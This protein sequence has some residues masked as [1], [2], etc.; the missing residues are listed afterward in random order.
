MA[1]LAM[2]TACGGT[3]D[4]E[5]MCGAH[6]DI[7]D[8]FN[9]Q[10]TG[11]DPIAQW[12]RAAGVSSSGVVAADFATLREQLAEIEGCDPAAT[13]TF[14]VSD[15]LLSTEP[16]P[17]L[18]SALCTG[19]TK[20]SDVF[21]AASFELIENGE[22]TGEIDTRAI[23]M[24]AWDPDSR[25]YRFYATQPQ[26]DSDTEV[27][28]EIDPARC[29]QCHTAP[30]DEQALA[31]PMTPIMNELSRP[32]THWNAAPGFPSHNFVVP[33]RT[34]AS[35]SY[36]ALATGCV[37]DDG[38]DGPCSASVFEGIIRKAH[39]KVVGA[40]TRKRRDPPDVAEAM[41]LLRPLFCP[42]QINYATEDFESGV[43]AGEVLID[44][45]L[46]NMFKAVRADDWPWA[47]LNDD[48]IRLGSPSG[49]EPVAQ[50]PI[51]GNADQAY[52]NRLVAL[53]ALSPTQVLAIRAL[54]WKH[55]VFS[56]FRCGLWQAASAR[57]AEAPPDVSE[58]ERTLDLM[59]ALLADIMTIDGAPLA[60]GVDE[61]VI[62]LDSATE[63]SVAALSDALAAG[64]IASATCGSAGEGFCVA[65]LDAF[66]TMIQAYVDGIVD[67]VDGREVLRS[68]RDARIC[69]VTERV[70][71]DGDRFDDSTS[72]RFANRPS[73][74]DVSCF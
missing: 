40:R 68:M 70:T 65:D 4:P 64:D 22:G 31:M 21:L 26:F 28:V 50:V 73:L 54:D 24:F 71:A 20:A 25:S 53:R 3:G 41:S 45:G 74:P 62:A 48:I 43:I 9:D 57:F 51:R 32:W 5:Q 36:Q 38:S 58:F 39:D 59:P 37:Q 17:R 7:G 30:A 52:E 34:L 2:A 33:E 12:L 56:D 16:F 60:T 55:P 18:V 63:E 35:A 67:D 19:D 6:C 13:K 49:D 66:G 14:V 46:R 15:D 61:Q 69:H 1:A 8:D 29:H 10:L 11:S 27:K 42:E 72:E 44:P 47:W 23:E